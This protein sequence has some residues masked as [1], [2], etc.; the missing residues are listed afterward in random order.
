MQCSAVPC[1]MSAYN[2]LCLYQQRVPEIRCLG[3]AVPSR[4][5][6]SGSVWDALQAPYLFLQQIRLSLLSVW[7]ESMFRLL[8][9]TRRQ[10]MGSALH[11]SLMGG[12]CVS[13][14]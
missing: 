14:R 1:G 9:D 7:R 4:Y 2:F 6:V 5:A 11:Y 8:V 12:A 10:P 3:E 13:E